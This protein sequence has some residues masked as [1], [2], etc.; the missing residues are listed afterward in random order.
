MT[1]D[2]DTIALSKALDAD[3]RAAAIHEAGHAVVAH[4][5]GADVSFVEM[6]LGTGNGASC[7]R[8]LGDNSKT[9]A[10]LVAGYKAE[11]AVAAHELN[12]SKMLAAHAVRPKR[13][14]QQMQELLLRLPELE[15]LAVL[16]EGFTLA[17]E[18]LKAN[19]DVVNRIADA[20][21]ARRFEDK[22]RI[23]GARWMCCSQPFIAAGEFGP[24]DVAML[25]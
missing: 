11:L 14:Y 5:L 16:V 18:K 1:N 17:D 12:L 15:R 24:A 21:F 20:L 7:S 9:L 3:E 23:E 10:V 22:A 8:N 19:A 13:D 4:A 25:R 2:A 6:D